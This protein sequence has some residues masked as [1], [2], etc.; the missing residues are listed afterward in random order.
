M[1]N[2]GEYIEAENWMT[3][4]RMLF[5]A[6]LKQSSLI[7]RDKTVPGNPADG[8]KVHSPSANAR[9]KMVS[10]NTTVLLLCLRIVQI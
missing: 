4:F 2:T 7:T 5:S 1:R 3:L 8:E 10:T 6:V 9:M